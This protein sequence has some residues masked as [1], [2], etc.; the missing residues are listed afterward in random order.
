[1]EDIIRIELSSDVQNTIE[2]VLQDKNDPLCKSD[3][4][5]TTYINQLFPNEIA[6]NGIDDI[7]S[8]MQIEV[9]QIDDN[10]HRVVKTVST[11]GTEGKL[12]LDEAKNTIH[13]LFSQI[14]DIKTRAEVTEEIVKNITSDIKQLDCAKKNLT[15]AITALNH[16]HMLVDGVE[17]L[18]LLAE[19]RMYGEISN[20]LQAITEV[21]HHFSQYNDIPQIKELSLSVAEI[22]KTLSTQI[23]EDFKNTF[24]ITASEGKMSLPKLR[25][26]CLIIS[27]LDGKVRRDLL[28]W[29]IS[30]FLSFMNQFPSANF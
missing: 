29:F 23:S 12:A 24:S 21:N 13:Q 6:L 16:L 25:D 2:Q 18:K 10:I 7:I 1:M 22:H 30:E 5:A 15:S 14:G 4:N 9:L 28:K 3:F 26:A 19:K 17:K 20:P 11:S 27:V 8:Q